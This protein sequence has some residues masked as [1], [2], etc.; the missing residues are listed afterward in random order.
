[1]N[2]ISSA[3][4]FNPTG[5]YVIM[6]NNPDD[7][8]SSHIIALDVLNFMLIGHHSVNVIFAYAVDML[9]YDVYTGDPY[10]GKQNDCGKMKTLKVGVCKDGKFE[11]PNLSQMLIKLPKVPAEMGSCT[12][13][14]CARIAEPFINEGCQSGMEVEILK[15]LRLAMTQL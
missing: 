6:Y 1:M 5:K 14:F 10:H 12:F 4:A 8:N 9:S 2:Y 15:L 7:R 13:K 11:Q 3:F